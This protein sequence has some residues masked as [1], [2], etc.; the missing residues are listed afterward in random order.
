IGVLDNDAGCG[1]K[2]AHAFPTG[3]GV[4][5]VV[6]GQFFALQLG[7]AAQQAGS[8]G[9]VDVEGG[10]LVWVFAVAQHLILLELQV[11]DARPVIA[12]GRL[13]LFGLVA[14]Q[15]AQVAGDCTVVGGGV[16]IDLG[17]KFQAQAV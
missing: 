1:F 3:I 16:S 17:G 11:Q 9:R 5:N 12:F 4:G 6:V 2:A 8:H 10:F 14:D 15:A 7:V 13:V